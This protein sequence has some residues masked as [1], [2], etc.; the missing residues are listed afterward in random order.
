MTDIVS[1]LANRCGINAASVQKAL[2]VVLQFL[3]S[4]LPAESFAK[5]SAAIPGADDMMAA[6]AQVEEPK[7][8]GMLEAVKGAVGKIFGSGGTDAALAKL[9]ALGL[10][11]DQMQTV[12]QHVLEFLKGKLPDNVMNQISGMLPVPH[13]TAH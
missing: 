1:E 5:L 9:G 8:A 6:A 10:S 4:K 7:S 2:G 13:E 12:L 3:K 11:A